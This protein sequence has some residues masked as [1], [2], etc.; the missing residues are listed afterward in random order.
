MTLALQLQQSGQFLAALDWYQTVYAYNLSAPERKI[1]DG[2]AREENLR[3]TIDFN[4]S[5]WLLEG[6][7]PHEFAFRRKNAYTRFTL[8]SLARCLNDFADAEYTRETDESIGRARGLYLTVL[9]LLGSELQAPVSNEGQPGIEPHSTTWSPNPIIEAL[10]LHAEL[11]LSKLREGRNIAGMERTSNVMSEEESV[12]PHATSYQPTQ[13]RYSVLIERA[14]EL[15]NMAQQVESAFLSALEK[16]DSEAYSLLHARHDLR[17]AQATVELQNLRVNHADIDI[18]LAQLQKERSQIQ[19]DTYQGWINDGFNEWENAMLQN[20]KDANT[21]QKWVAGLDAA[22]TTAQASLS[23]AAVWAFS[24]ELCL[25]RA[26]ASV[27]G[28]LAGMKAVFVINAENAAM[29]AQIN[30]F[31]ASHER[32]KQE[33]FLQK[34]IA[35]KDVMIGEQQGLSAQLQRRMAEQE[36]GIA[37]I[38]SSQASQTVEFLANK[39]T[40]VDLY[41]FMAGVMEG[42]FRYFL[43]Q[44]IAVARLAQAQLAFERQETLPSLILT[45]YWQSSAETALIIGGNVVTTVSGGS[46]PDRQG[47]TGSARLLRDIYQLDQFAFDTRKRKLQLAQAFSLARLFPFEFQRFRDTG[48]LLFST[49]MELFDREF[50]G[51]YLRVI[52]RV[53]TSVVALIPPVQGIRA[54]LSASSV[55]RVVV[56][57]DIFGTV[58]VR[59][60]PESIAFTSPVNATGLL[61][62]E[63][64]GELLL[65]FE[66]SGVDTLWKLELPKPAN[67]FDF[68]TIADVVLTLEYTALSSYDYRQQVI[69]RLNR[70]VGGERPFSLRNDFPDIWY[71]LNNAGSGPVGG[72]G[73]SQDV[74]ITFQTGPRDF[75]PNITVDEIKIDHLLLFFSF[76]EGV[77]NGDDA[78]GLPRIHIKSLRLNGLP[79]DETNTSADSV[80]GLISTRRNSGTNWTNIRGKPFGT[81]E[82]SLPKTELQHFTDG[83]IEDILFVIIWSARTPP[84]PE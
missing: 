67:P 24:Q 83:K 26:M 79:T 37:R 80:E 61:D 32:R 16:R 33:W 82:L 2:L 51:H 40:N 38:Q 27:V 19:A 63:P 81:W 73:L 4:P 30:A 3:S 77:S 55:S 35:D 7:N 39:F 28:T 6:L 11:S 66:G 75:P 71:E 42:V 56:G 64:E 25:T 8:I 68:S 29:S 76:A 78:S 74:V 46:Q 47:L 41:D 36:R 9:D 17:L 45:D 57:P 5:D 60:S 18:R 22:L 21:A 54:T 10:H 1:Y 31:K 12:L 65:P 49:P 84:W 59:R 52:K 23:A 58:E 20:H 53:R 69:K 48:T 62:L 13:Y 50:P 34:G 43:Q 14:K 15:V 72:G 44:A 70:V